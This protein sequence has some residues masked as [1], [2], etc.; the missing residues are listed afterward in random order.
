MTRAELNEKLKAIIKPYVNN[1]EAFN[2]ISENT[3]LLKDLRINSA[4]LVD[5][6]LDV[7][8]NFDIEVDDASMEKMLTVKDALDV[9]EEKLN[10]R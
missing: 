2:S 8:D 10:D 9:I 4:H 5:V 3:D 1:E 6:I 7:E